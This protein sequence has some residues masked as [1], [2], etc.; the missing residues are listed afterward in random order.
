MKAHRCPRVVPQSLYARLTCRCE[1]FDSFPNLD[2]SNF[3]GSLRV[4]D[5]FVATRDI[6]F[7]RFRHVSGI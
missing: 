3:S 2:I 7:G 5:I 4:L 1:L 6:V